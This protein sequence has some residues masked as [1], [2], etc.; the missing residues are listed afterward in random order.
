MLTG[1]VWFLT[2]LANSDNESLYSI[3]RVSGWL[4]EPLLLYLLLAF[5]T[6]RLE[7]RI[8]RALVGAMVVLAL[9]LYLPTAL[10][11]ERYPVPGPWM[12]CTRG[13]PRQRLHAD[14]LAAGVHRG[15]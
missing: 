5:P 8:D 14:R 15:P 10:L 9:V 7:S 6:G 3:G 12:T 4:V 1:F 2:T 13:V 11:I